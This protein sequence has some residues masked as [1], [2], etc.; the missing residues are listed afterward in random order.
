MDTTRLAVWVAGEVR[1]GA[2]ARRGHG[3]GPAALATAAGLFLAV[4][5]VV[6][7]A[8]PQ[9]SAAD[10]PPLV[11]STPNFGWT[12]GEFSVSDD[13]AAQYNLPLWV[14]P[15][16]GRSTPELAL[17][18]NSRGGNGLLGVGWS[19]SGLSSIT[20]CPRTFAQDGFSDA[21]RLD[22]TDALCLDGNRLLPQGSGQ[23]RTYKTERETFARIT[24]YGIANNVPSYFRVESRDGLI[25]TYGQ[26]GDSR[27]AGLRL[28][29][30]PDPDDPDEMDFEN[31]DLV[32]QSLTARFTVGWAVNK[33][34]DRNGNAAT[35]EYL[36]DFDDP[37]NTVMT[38]SVIRY[39]PNRR[40]QFVYET[41]PRPDPIDAYG[42]GVH[43]RS[44]R[45]LQRIE[46]WGGPTTEEAKKLREYGL[47]YINSSES[48]RSLLTEIK[49]CDQD[50]ICKKPLPLRYSFGD[51]TFR[52]MTETNLAG[53]MDYY[54][55]WVLTG[56]VNA[57]GRGDLIYQS[58]DAD[59][60]WI[61]RGTGT[62]SGF[63]APVESPGVGDINQH[64]LPRR[65]LR[66]VVVDVDGRT[67][68]MADDEFVSF[69]HEGHRWQLFE[70]DG[71]KFAKGAGGDLGVFYE[72]DR[73]VQ[74]PAYLG[75]VD[76]NGLADFVPVLTDLQF[77]GKFWG[78]R[79]NTGATGE[80]RFAPF[81]ITQAPDVEDFGAQVVDT[82]GDGRAEI[83]Q[84]R[85]LPDQ[86]PGGYTVW[87]RDAAGGIET[88][89]SN[90]ANSRKGYPNDYLSM[91][92]TFGDLNG[93]GLDDAVVVERT[94]PDD[95]VTTWRL[96]AQLNSGNGFG[97]PV[98]PNPPTWTFEP[99]GESNG[100]AMGKMVVADFNGDG[101][102]DVLMEPFD[103][104]SCNGRAELYVW[105]DDRFI[106]SWIMNN[107][108]CGALPLDVDADGILDL[109]VGVDGDRRIQAIR[110]LGGVPDR[111]TGI[112]LGTGQQVEIEYTNL[113][114]RDV[115]TPC[116]DAVYPLVCRAAGGSV[117]KMHRVAT[118]APGTSAW[119]TFTHTYKHGRA[120]LQ[121]RGWLGFAEHTVNRWL[122]G[123]ITVTTFDNVTRDDTLKVYPYAGLPKTVT[124]DVDPLSQGRLFRR[125]TVNDNQ[126]RRVGAGYTVEPQSVTVTE[127]DRLSTDPTWQTLRT[128]T[129]TNTFDAYGNPDLVVSMTTGGR[130]V[131]SNP[132]FDNDTTNWLIGLRKR[133]VT[134]GCDVANRCVART[135]RFE[136][137]PNG[138]PRLT[139]VEP[140]RPA[141]KLTTET[142]Y[143][144]F[145]NVTSVMRTDN[146]GQVRTDGF[147]YDGNDKLYPS[148]TVNALGHRTVIETHS[149]LGV[150]TKVIDP[151]GVATRMRYDKFGRL[152]E[153]NRADG[154]FEH[155]TYEVPTSI[156][157]RT[158]TTMSGGG[159]STE[160]V[161]RL[162]RPI[163]QTVKAFDG[164]IATTYTDYDALGRVAKTSRPTFP[165][166]ARQDTLHQYDNL[167]RPIRTTAPDGA[168][169]THEY[170]GLETHT[171]DAKNVHSYTVANKDG[172]VASSFEDDPDTS[173]WLETSFAY[174]GFGQTTRID[175]PGDTAQTMRYDI[176]GRQDQLVD[177]SSGTTTTTYTAFGEVFTETD[178]TG[179]MS[180]YTYDA[181]G[182]VK[183]INS[184]DGVTTNTWDT[185][186]FGVG[187][188]HSAD[189]PDSVFTRYKYDQF[190]HQTVVS[191]KIENED[192]QVATGY[193]QIGR[194]ASTTYPH[195]FLPG[196]GYRRLRVDYVY[197]PRGYLSEVRD[198]AA[199]PEALP[200][201]R[202]GGQNA[203]GQLTKE[204]LGNGVV[205]DYVYKPETGL[206]D[207]VTVTGPG[208]AGKLAEVAYG[209]DLN[210]NVTLRHDKVNQRHESYG[211][212]ELNRLETWQARPSA[213][214]GPVLTSGFAY[215]E[216]GNLTTE[217]TTRPGQPQQTITY[218]YGYQQPDLAAPPHA[219]VQ[220]DAYRG[221][222][223]DDAGRQTTAPNR[224]VT[225][226]TLDLPRT[227]DTDSGRHMQ[228]R[229]DASGA[230]ALKRDQ[231]TTTVT[232]GEWFERRSPSGHDSSEIHNLNNIIVD[233]RI[234]AQV[235]LV[236][237]AGGGEITKTVP[238][239]VH[240]DAQGSTT[241]VT[242]P[243]GEPYRGDESIYNNLYYDPWGRRIDDTYQPVPNN[244]I[245]GPRQLYTA[246]YHDDEIYL[247]NMK[248][249]MYDPVDRRFL[250]AD[251]V[252]ADPLASQ[253]LNRYPYVRNNPTTLTD[254]TGLCPECGAAAPAD[255]V[256]DDFLTQLANIFS[257]DTPGRARVSTVN[258]C[259]C[260]AEGA[261]E[262][263]DEDSGDIQST[264]A[265]KSSPD[266]DPLAEALNS[267]NMADGRG[268]LLAH[269]RKPP[270]PTPWQTL[271]G[272]YFRGDVGGD[273]SIIDEPEW[274][275]YMM[276]NEILR[277]QLAGHVTATARAAL[278]TYL[279]GKGS[280]DYHH[281]SFPAVIEN[282]FFNGYQLLH[283]TNADVGGFE[284]VS[285]SEVTPNRD[286]TFGVRLMS[287]Y[288]W[289]D[290]I[291]GKGNERFS[292]YYFKAIS[293][294]RAENYNVHITWT[295]QTN[296]TLGADGSIA[297]MSGYPMVR[298]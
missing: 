198:S 292:H 249:R 208:E 108:G 115:H 92:A 237:P 125:V 99:P 212:D 172:E 51:V 50:A 181:L 38:P 233:G 60:T 75:D 267:V 54:L 201:W 36:W 166:Q 287:Q 98:Q 268:D 94:F 277:P 179:A 226:S 59:T 119:D 27:L 182:R 159:V 14:P 266:I 100:G 160:L 143:D 120:D 205:T 186:E 134:T 162:N 13:G 211:H 274:T 61:Q 62:G 180:T 221:Y 224:H 106:L 173:A 234:V 276:A 196:G 42:A 139:I 262:P 95:N 245:A 271:F 188:L 3:R 44:D 174:D 178:A 148:A 107:L 146:A 26:T 63:S 298:P 297:G 58:R 136:Y 167:D 175:A 31:P 273:L 280:V 210:R 76:G 41:N 215:D 228:F 33:I 39:E 128:R 204:H 193:D 34:E 256:F 138:N 53:R 5:V 164:R 124:F 293:F 22:G 281:E 282:G 126:I 105:R 153:T 270:T 217:T 286:G 101:R 278:R 145:G 260:V 144:T 149:G 285:R 117:V 141:F 195:V 83:L 52:R 133:Q 216:V 68:V 200:Y 242:G 96:R 261:A 189:S 140:D 142:F 199:P 230:R 103:G 43:M 25:L 131:T 197:N 137:Y 229:Y 288:T 219:L 253:S 207:T 150:Q 24:G 296:F 243:N 81:Q 104:P 28:K 130:K 290:I 9:A 109:V 169:V 223:Y 251:P 4:L 168:V 7:G 156:T 191:W 176:L 183:R 203:A 2:H 102:D 67:D 97:S 91:N 257:A 121:G 154:S 30:K 73:G 55:L 70:S 275:K 177:P 89:L 295:A 206:M 192:F 248:G 49:E 171:R 12:Q 79:L 64:G 123:A 231:F 135:S 132:T 85:W 110:H 294:G 82:D 238:V 165:A 116:T 246:Q 258:G 16:R 23:Q 214:A 78:Y 264:P 80:D 45:R 161:D 247:I 72:A 151:N 209:Y 6:A 118:L 252:I 112:G 40:V 222:R 283:G 93:D 202:V 184:P 111:L 127:Q 250:T 87:G 239:Y 284:I 259:V 8:A 10:P 279:D 69:G 122:S 235:N 65:A 232:A 129:T 19:V 225:Y 289:N 187:K 18:Y 90:V 213:T 35:V 20:W 21:G 263:N 240:P 272:H 37:N 265:D 254:P 84:Q 56:D 241:L 269:L 48:G 113:A 47:R 157:Q 158:T 155:V 32:A 46:M 114:D 152:R 190:G 86:V 218:Q 71:S 66:P 88:G 147:E 220:R 236:Q 74:E 194:V 244:R 17:A 163:Q 57:D 29:P 291:D 227:V 77:G 255:N 11:A 1:R 170:L 15:G 185:A